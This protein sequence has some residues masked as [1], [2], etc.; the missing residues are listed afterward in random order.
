MSCGAQETPQETELVS[1]Y[2]QPDFACLVFITK[3]DVNAAKAMENDTSWWQNKLTPEV[4]NHVAGVFVQTP[5]EA[6]VKHL[7]D[8]KHT[9]LCGG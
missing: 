1:L 6:E 2:K 9:S 8:I 4:H 5:K 7:L 3:S